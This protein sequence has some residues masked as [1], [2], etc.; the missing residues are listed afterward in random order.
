VASVIGGHATSACGTPANVGALGA[1][2]SL[3]PGVTTTANGS[4]VLYVAGGTATG[5][6]QTIATAGATEVS[7]TNVSTGAQS[8]SD[9]TSV[10]A[11]EAV[12][13]SGT[14][15]AAAFTL[16]ASTGG[17]AGFAVEVNAA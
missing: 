11:W 8:G 17:R 4:I 2:T 6:A 15:A 16:G 3:A 1:G 12:P 13:T 7:G 10:L 5:V 14:A 9:C